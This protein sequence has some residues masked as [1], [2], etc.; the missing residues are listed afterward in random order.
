MPRNSKRR[1]ALPH[2]A[3]NCNPHGRSARVANPGAVCPCYA[4]TPL[5]QQS[6][7][8]CS[9]PQVHILSSGFSPESAGGEHIGVAALRT[10][11]RARALRLRPRPTAFAYG[12]TLHGCRAAV[13]PSILPFCPCFLPVPSVLLSL[14]A[15]PSGLRYLVPPPSA[16][17]SLPLEGISTLRFARARGR[18]GG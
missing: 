7:Y 12:G 11:L 15:V 3:V 9:V 18:S 1:T 2:E 5:P 4:L 6:H 17:L 8:P 14:E 10:A 13:T 16:A